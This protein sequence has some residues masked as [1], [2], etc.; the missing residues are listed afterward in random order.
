ME[1]DL[2]QQMEKEDV[3]NVTAA[4]IA[5]ACKHPVPELD[6]PPSFESGSGSDSDGEHD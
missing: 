3:P 1:S 5:E 6:N 2:G 4:A